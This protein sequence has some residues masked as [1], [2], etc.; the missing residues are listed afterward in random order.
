M[1]IHYLQPETAK[2]QQSLM[3][4]EGYALAFRHKHLAI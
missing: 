3:L 2:R 4:P 1:I